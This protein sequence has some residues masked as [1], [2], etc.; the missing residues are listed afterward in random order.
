MAA[1]KI[2]DYLKTKKEEKSI[3]V[4]VDKSLYEEAEKFKDQSKITWK[5][6]IEACLKKYV[7]ESK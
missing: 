5:E 6:L 4:L 1:K 2:K 3:M 7:D